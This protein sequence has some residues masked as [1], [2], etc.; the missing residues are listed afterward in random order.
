MA[1]KPA[2]IGRDGR[3]NAIIRALR[4]S[5][6]VGDVIQLTDWRGRT[7]P[8]VVSALLAAAR[9]ERPDFI[10]IGPE[11]PLAAG[12][13]D[14]FQGELGIPCV[15]PTRALARLEAS[16][17][18]TRALLEKHGIPG[19]PRHRV[20]TSM[21]PEL[22][23]YLRELGEFVVKPDGLT[24]GKGVKVSGVHLAGH[25]EALAYCEELLAGPHAAVVIE[26]K[27]DGEE[28]SLQSFCDGR[29]LVDMPAVQDHKRAYEGDE[30]PNTGGMGSYSDGDH[31]LPFLTAGQVA[32]ASAI[33]AAVAR[34]LLVET[35]EPYRGVLYGGFM[36]T[37]DGVR[38]IEYNA[39][40]GDPEALNVLPLLRTPLA[41][42]CEAIVGGTL[43]DAGVTFD[44]R[45]TVC[46]YIVPVGYP[47]APVRGERIDL[48]GLPRESASFHV[49]PA[50]VEEREDGLYLL[51]SRAVALVGIGDTL[52]EAYDIA[53]RA[54]GAVKGP[55]F[56]RRDIGTAALIQ[57]RVDHMRQLAADRVGTV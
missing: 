51:G 3:T 9:R 1:L 44:R 6:G 43:A 13:V 29:N 45:A 49:Y 33:N 8:E 12:V 48:S 53:E 5:P 41:R 26:E 55:V 10:V 2:V 18:F 16:K 4:A 39:R 54:A 30:G 37:R 15:G 57:R 7:T 25:H 32:E 23:A 34:A 47:D 20:F 11:E 24:G 21:G 40:L 22:A 52:P 14:A 50:S 27:L 46:K 28:F 35:G 42:V 17:A 38:L 36:A 19:N 56:Y 31:L